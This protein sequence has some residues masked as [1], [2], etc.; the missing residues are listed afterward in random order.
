MG[1]INKDSDY[2]RREVKVCNTR[3]EAEMYRDMLSQD[4]I[5]SIIFAK[6][7]G[8]QHP[9]FNITGVHLMVNSEDYEKA[10]EVLGVGQEK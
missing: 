8:R 1:L 9:E 6:D 5:P 4:N 10:C 3:E 2:G 7:V